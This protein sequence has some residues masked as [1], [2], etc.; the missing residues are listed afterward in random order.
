M[1]SSMPLKPRCQ[2]L[3]FSGQQVLSGI[4]DAFAV[5]DIYSTCK[6]CYYKT[7][8]RGKALTEGLGDEVPR[9]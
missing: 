2:R 3:S 1:R 5:L 6:S 4:R 8:T 7:G 9:S